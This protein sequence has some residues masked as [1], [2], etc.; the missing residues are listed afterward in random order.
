[1]YAPAREPIVP[2]IT[3]TDASVNGSPNVSAPRAARK[4]AGI[5]TTSLG[6]GMNELSTVMKK[7]TKKKPQTGAWTVRASIYVMRVSVTVA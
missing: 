6:N 1:M 5:I 3:A 2:A 4:P 7:K